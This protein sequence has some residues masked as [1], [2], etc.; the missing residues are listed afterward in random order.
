LKR[1]SIERV[2]EPEAI[3]GAMLGCRSPPWAG[4]DH[5]RTVGRE[6]QARAVMVCVTK[7]PLTKPAMPWVRIVG[8]P[9]PLN[10]G[11]SAA[12]PSRGSSVSRKVKV[13]VIA[14]A[15]PARPST[16]AARESAT[17]ERTRRW[18]RSRPLGR[19]LIARR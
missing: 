18:R 16:E 1:T 19:R 3:T 4:K 2:Y 12:P 15:G 13:W 10:T 9:D 5:A 14:P 6:A 17:D 11:T 7:L 8:A